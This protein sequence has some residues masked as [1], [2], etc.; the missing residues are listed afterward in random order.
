[1]VMKKVEE[2][3]GLPSLERVTALIPDDKRLRL[4][5]DILAS[6]ER[7]AKGASPEILSSVLEV[8]RLVGEMPESKLAEVSAILRR[9]ERLSKAMPE[10]LAS[11]IGGHEVAK[12]C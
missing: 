6:A 11:L 3:F 1:M 7:L 9:V 8:L 2:M 4:V 5:K 12:G 10:S